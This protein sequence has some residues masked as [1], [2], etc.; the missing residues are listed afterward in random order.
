MEVGREGQAG[1]PE[2]EWEILTLRGLSVTD[3]TA[4]EF[5]GALVIHR[6]GSKEPVEQV[7][8]RVKRA[9]LEE[10]ATALKRVLTRSTRYAR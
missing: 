2:A 4:E 3:E 9:V 10:L 6:S 5:T 1:A 8:V 7:S